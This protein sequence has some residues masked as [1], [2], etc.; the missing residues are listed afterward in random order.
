MSSDAE[1]KVAPTKKWT[2]KRIYNL[3][4]YIIN[5]VFIVKLFLFSLLK[6]KRVL[7]SDNFCTFYVLITKLVKDKML[8]VCC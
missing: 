6:T 7:I 3:K 4:P 8:V 2:I 1:K 5:K